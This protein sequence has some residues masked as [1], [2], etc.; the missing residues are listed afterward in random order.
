MTTRLLLPPSH[1][2]CRAPSFLH[3]S[4]GGSSDWSRTLQDEVGIECE[5]AAQVPV[6]GP[7]PPSPSLSQFTCP[8]EGWLAVVPFTTCDLSSPPP[9]PQ[10]PLTALP[11]WLGSSPASRAPLPVA[12]SVSIPS[13]ERSPGGT[14]SQARLPP[15]SAAELPAQAGL[16]PVPQSTQ[17][18]VQ[19]QLQR[20]PTKSRPRLC[21]ATSFVSLTWTHRLP[22]QG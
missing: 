6:W 13:A 9:S 14:A 22:S 8:G 16:A 4:P 1:P 15:R 11:L 20:V 10:L 19:A 12:A 5:N 3:L 21:P 17:P 2:S 7:S 18:G